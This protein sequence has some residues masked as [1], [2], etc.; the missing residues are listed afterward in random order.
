MPVEYK[1]SIVDELAMIAH[2]FRRPLETISKSAELVNRAQATENLE[3]EKLKEIMNG[4]IISCHRLS[5]LTSQ[6][7]NLSQAEN[8]NLKIIIEELNIVDFI[9]E[10][11]EYIKYYKEQKNINIRFNIKV[12]NPYVVCDFKKLERILLNLIS[13]AIKYSPENKRSITVKIYDEDE[14]LCF[15][16]KDKGIGIPES[17]QIKIFNKFYRLENFAT[18]KIE[19]CGLGLTIVKTFTEILGGSI[20]VKS[21]EGKGSEFIVRIPKTQQSS[22]PCKVLESTQPYQLFKSSVDEIFADI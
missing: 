13:N 3:P 21:T 12:K 1:N 16:V 6:I 10:I 2:E 19:G 15:S 11:E 14:L 17:E 18:R 8:S 22:L 7:Y 20:E 5:L 9:K 4:I